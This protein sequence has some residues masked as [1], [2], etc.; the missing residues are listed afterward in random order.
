M[1]PK[2]KGTVQGAGQNAAKADPVRQGRTQSRSS[3]PRGTLRVAD[4]MTTDVATVAIHATLREVVELLTTEQIH[5]APVIEG[6]R[7][8]GVISM[9][10][11]L[12]FMSA[13]PGVPAH[14]AEQSEWEEWE[15]GGTPEER[16]LIPADFFV[17]LWA[18]AGADSF[19]RFREVDGAEWDLLEEHTAE[20]IMTRKL[21]LLSPETELRQAARHM[22]DSGVHR[23]LV[24]ED[25][26]LVGIVSTTDILKAV[27]EGK[28]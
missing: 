23:L 8:A 21:C 22:L 18:D 3:S 26:T 12:E 25:H 4:I 28:R 6:S 11:V 5:G 7:V 1:S 10:D 9:T 27:A 17:G 19:A 16:D 2:K 24:V 15:A 14:H 20:E 13:A